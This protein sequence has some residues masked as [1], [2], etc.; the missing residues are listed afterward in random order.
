MGETAPASAGV[1]DGRRVLRL[2][3]NFAGTKTERASWDRA[4]RL[5]LGPARGVQF[6]IR[7]LDASPVSYFSIYFQ[8]GEGWYHAAFYPE[9]RRAGIPLRLTKPRPPSRASRPAGATSAEFASPPGELR[10]SNTEFW[11][12]DIRPVWAAGHGCLGRHLARRVR[13]PPFGRGKGGASSSS[14]RGVARHFQALDIGCAVVSDL[15]VSA[16]SLK[17][18]KL[19]VL[20]HNPSMPDLAAEA[21][22]HYLEGGG[23][24]LVFY[25]LR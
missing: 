22:T 21:L 1:I 16:E 18:A 13:R 15:D 12:S 2:A 23:K 24:L 6:R 20:P 14:P 7:C 3:C 9:L 25:K 4:V 5:D 17:K 10:M 11:L 8:S 19:V